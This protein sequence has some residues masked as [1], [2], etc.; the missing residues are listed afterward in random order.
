M[1]KKIN[2]SNI[3]KFQNWFNIYIFFE[4]LFRILKNALVLVN[5]T[6]MTVFP[7]LLFV[8]L[9]F[10]QMLAKYD[11][12][13]VKNLMPLIVNVL[14]KTVFNIRMFSIQ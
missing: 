5:M 2:N 6:L 8:F 11:Q 1:M 9:L 12:D 13:V 7:C 4:C 14:G 3:L 10:V